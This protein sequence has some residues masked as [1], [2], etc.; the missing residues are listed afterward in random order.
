MKMIGKHALEIFIKVIKLG[1]LIFMKPRA[2]RDIIKCIIKSMFS[3]NTDLIEDDTY[4][5]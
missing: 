1:F 4:F 2:E 5:F 3:H